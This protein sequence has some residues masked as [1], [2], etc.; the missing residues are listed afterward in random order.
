MIL[1]IFIAMRH[2]WTVGLSWPRAPQARAEIRGPVHLVGSLLFMGG[3]AFALF[4]I[5]PFAVNFW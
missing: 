1:G 4:V 5:I 2:L 3:G